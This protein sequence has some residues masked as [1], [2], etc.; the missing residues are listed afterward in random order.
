M[1]IIRRVSVDA[2]NNRYAIDPVYR[3]RQKAAARNM[4]RANSGTSLSSCLRNLEKTDAIAETVAV[5]LPDGT[6]RN[7]PVIGLHSLAELLDCTY[8]TIVRWVHV[9]QLPAPILHTCANGTPCYHA[10][11]ARAFVEIIGNHQNEMRYFRRDHN[12]AILA[13]RQ[14]IAAVRDTFSQRNRKNKR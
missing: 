12:G 3:D 8:Q 1:P 4:Y 6:M 14:R 5:Q 7:W 10:D 9:G 13:I 2:R 11:E